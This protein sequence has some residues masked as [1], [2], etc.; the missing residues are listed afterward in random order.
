VSADPGAEPTPA[1]RRQL[2]A[3]TDLCALTLSG[4]RSA[5]VDG[6]PGGPAAWLT[7][8]VDGLLDSAMLLRPLRDRDGW[9]TDFLI[10]HTNERF[11]DPAGRPGGA[12]TGLR[13]LEAYPLF[14]VEGGLFERIQQVC[15]TGVPNRTD[16]TVLRA[17]AGQRSTAA[18]ACVGL[19]RFGDA[20]VLTWRLEEGD[21]RLAAL[22]HHTQRLSRI[23]GFEENLVTGEIFWNEQLYA[24]H[25]LPPDAD[26]VPLHHLGKHAHPDDTAAIARFLRTVLNHREEDA[27]TFRLRRAD[28]VVRHVRLVAEP[29]CDASGVLA[30]VRG[31]Y[32][33]VS[34]QRWTEVALAA[35]RDRL[36]GAE[37]HAA[38][39]QRLAR[40]LQQAIMQPAD[41]PVHT[42][43][44]RVAVRYRAAEEDNRVGG[45]WYDAVML[46]G[47]HV[48]LTVGDVAGHSIT[49][50]NGMVLLRNALRGLAITGAGPGQLLSWLNNVAHN[51]TEEVTATVICGI[52]EPATRTLRWARAGHLPPILVRRG[53]AEALPMPEGPLLG[54]VADPSYEEFRLELEP[55]DTLLMYTDGLIERRDSSV[56]D[57]LDRL[58]TAASSSFHD[59]DHFLD[60]LLSTSVADTDD[61][62]CL[63]GIQ[64]G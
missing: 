19:G 60:H 11:V 48:L 31:A 24:L 49:A 12:L 54:A 47:G 38:E 42:V 28:G 59:L 56:Q 61:D 57:A 39:R 29:I 17:Q 62:T 45:D 14:A 63:L 5:E 1:L 44:L 4:S 13:L 33:D 43:G 7:G 40:Q 58:L 23:G 55:R 26:P 41:Q 35:T 30:A 9:I 6:T 25:G 37:E 34:S 2:E 53:S 10:E 32:Q 22:L 27:V 52:F 64:P 8:L 18:M 15:T 46:P 20:V 51:L 3:L 50:V 36:A 21:A 16:S